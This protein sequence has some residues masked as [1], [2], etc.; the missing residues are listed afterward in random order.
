MSL[1]G[2][3]DNLQFARDGGEL[4]GTLSLGQLPRL[5]GMSCKTSGVQF[6]LTGGRNRSGKPSIEVRAR[7]RLEVPCQR[8]LE[9][10]EFGIDVEVELELCADPVWIAQAD[11]DI[12]RIL[13]DREMS[14]A[15]LV[16]DELILVFP[17][18]PR[19]ENCRIAGLPEQRSKQSPFVA[20]AELKRRRSP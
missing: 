11:D 18:F 3:I 12:D 16:E 15:Q 19:H 14:V 1:S 20:L 10:M 8:C 5:A 7:G 17:Q 9:P 6:N 4:S 2:V 13:V